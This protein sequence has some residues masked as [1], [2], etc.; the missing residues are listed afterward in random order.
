M[1][2]VVSTATGG[3]GRRKS[4]GGGRAGLG[5]GEQKRRDWTLGSR[6]LVLELKRRRNWKEGKMWK[7]EDDGGRAAAPVMEVAVGG[8]SGRPSYGTATTAVERQWGGEPATK[9]RLKVRLRERKLQFF[10]SF[11]GTI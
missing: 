7:T 11:R 3:R 8:R 9:A 10:R 6:N 1:G 5:T 2:E 4:E